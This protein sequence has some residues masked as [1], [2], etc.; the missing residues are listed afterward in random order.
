MHFP[1]VSNFFFTQTLFYTMHLYVPEWEP[2][3]LTM[4]DRVSSPEDLETVEKSAKN[5]SKAAETQAA[6]YHG[7]DILISDKK[8]P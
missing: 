1:P 3:W 5:D 7:L 4:N 8:F 2:N 6:S